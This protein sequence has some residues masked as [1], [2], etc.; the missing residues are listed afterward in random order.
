MI[1]RLMCPIIPD[2]QSVFVVFYLWLVAT[3][4]LI[5]FSVLID[6][7]PKR[8]WSCDDRGRLLHTGS[9]WLCGSGRIPAIHQKTLKMAT[10][11]IFS[12]EGSPGHDGSDL[13]QSFVT[14][15]MFLFSAF[16]W[17]YYY[18]AFYSSGGTQIRGS[19]SRQEM[20]DDAQLP[21]T[22]TWDWLII[23]TIT[24]GFALLWTDWDISFIH[25]W[26]LIIK[27]SMASYHQ[28]HQ[29]SINFDKGGSALDWILCRGAWGRNWHFY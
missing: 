25:L 5:K 23:A 10:Y 24:F 13:W 2:I 12:G 3:I 29:R 14:I 18:V 4:D 20:N 9:S 15:S 17:G 11:S 26:D 16:V 6:R 28:A 7:P 1:A 27:K 22:N 19:R 8:W 21:N